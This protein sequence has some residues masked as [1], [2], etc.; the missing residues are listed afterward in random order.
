MRFEILDEA[1]VSVDIEV[2][3]VGRLHDRFDNPDRAPPTSRRLERHRFLVDFCSKLGSLRA[4]LMKTV[5]LQ[6]Q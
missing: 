4:T 6:V 5:Q 2:G 1:I 3:P